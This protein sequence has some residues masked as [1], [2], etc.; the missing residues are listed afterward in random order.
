MK[1]VIALIAVL[2]LAGGCP[3]PEQQRET[4]GSEAPAVS[5]PV[6]VVTLVCSDL[7]LADGEFVRKADSALAALAADGRIEYRSAGELPEELVQAADAVDVGMPVPGSTEPGCMTV[8][9]ACAV[10][11]EVEE[12]GWLVLTNTL[13]LEH[14]LARVASGEL[15]AGLILVLDDYGLAE[16]PVDPPVPVY[17]VS[18]D[19]R[20]MAFLLGVTAAASS[21]NGMFVIMAAD[22]DPHAADFMDGVWAGAKYHTNGAVAAVT[23]VPVDPVTGMVTPESYHTALGKA[24]D[25]MGSSFVSNHYILA[26]GRATPSIMNA[27]SKKPVNGYT[28]GGYG[29]FTAVRPARVLGCA[30]KN[31]GAAIDYILSET[32]ADPAVLADESGV[33]T[34]GLEQGAVGFTDFQLYQRYNP[35]GDDLAAEYETNMAEIMAGELDVNSLIERFNRNGE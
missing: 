30:L 9:T 15:D 8:T 13:L 3:Q 4:A 31:T 17:I 22:S 18:Y 34:V 19:I 12:T 24:K 29:D 32:D 1:R 10:V 16:P 27:V 33:I 7:G 5:A 26:L 25:R 23:T 35:D 28:A 11:N 6:P 20:P 14:A 2:L 21:N